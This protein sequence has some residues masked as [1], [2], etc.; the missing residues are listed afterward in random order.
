MPCK[1]Y[2]ALELGIPLAGAEQCNL[3]HNLLARYT[4]TC[5]NEELL[6]RPDGVLPVSASPSG[7]C[8]G[9]AAGPALDSSGSM[10]A[11]PSCTLYSLMRCFNSAICAS[12][13]RVRAFQPSA[14]L[15][16]AL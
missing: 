4:Y 12:A 8:Q 6:G 1:S 15:L 2:E 3:M 14:S 16:A 11:R 7:L 9:K 5:C 10:G 13:C